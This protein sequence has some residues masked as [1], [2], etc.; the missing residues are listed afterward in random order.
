M[1]SWL[2]AEDLAYVRSEMDYGLPDTCTIY[3]VAQTSTANGSSTTRTARAG[4]IGIPCRFASLQGRELQRAQQIASEADM[5]VTLSA[6]TVVETSDEIDV[7]HAETGR[8]IQ[9]QVQ[10]VIRRSQEM[11]RVV[12]C[13]E[14]SA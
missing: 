13:Q 7:T 6:N 3:S 9:L 4:E 11:R 14:L 2:A 8:V 5:T 10:A 1:T 12:L